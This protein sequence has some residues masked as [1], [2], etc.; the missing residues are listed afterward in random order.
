MLAQEKS[1]AKSSI[2]FLHS[3]WNKY[4]YLLGVICIHKMSQQQQHQKQQKNRTTFLIFISS[5]IYPFFPSWLLVFHSIPFSHSVSLLYNIFLT[6]LCPSATRDS[7]R[8]IWFPLGVLKA[9]NIFFNQ[10]TYV[11][12]NDKY[13]FFHF[14]SLHFT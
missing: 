6:C 11:I 13:I 1:S 14:F 2:K 8:R 4:L 7:C 12:E 10:G 5:I 3:K 9:Q